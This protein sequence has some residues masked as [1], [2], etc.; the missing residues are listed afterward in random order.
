VGAVLRQSPVS[1]RRKVERRLVELD[2][3]IAAGLIPPDSFKVGPMLDWEAGDMAFSIAFLL[4]DSKHVFALDSWMDLDQLPE[5]LRACPQL[6]IQKATMREFAREDIRAAP[7]SLIF[8]NTVT[9]HL[10]ELPQDFRDAYRILSPRGFLFT[11]HDN[12]YQPAG[13]HDH[14]FLFYGSRNRVERMGPACWLDVNK[15]QASAAH[16]ERIRQDFPWTWD[17]RN[18]RSMDPT[19]CPE[20][21]YYMRSQAW[22]HLIF[23]DQFLSLYPQACFHTGVEGASLNKIT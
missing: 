15:C 6:T 1:F 4:R 11:N 3:Y 13:S 17:E 8:A 2:D 23:R 18:E 14:G 21:H 16:R 22:A 20:C 10:Q 7:M 12:Y 9:E 19:N 5:P